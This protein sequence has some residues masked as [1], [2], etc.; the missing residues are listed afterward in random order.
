MIKTSKPCI[1]LLWSNGKTVRLNV[2]DTYLN[3]NEENLY[4][5]NYNMD[6]PVI[7]FLKRSMKIIF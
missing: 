7:K 1:L 2:L 3:S 4:I 5:H 6:A